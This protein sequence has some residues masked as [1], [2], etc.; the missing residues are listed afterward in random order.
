MS[1][2]Y[3]SQF[4]RL[5]FVLPMVFLGACGDDDAARVVIE[6]E[7]VVAKIGA[8][9]DSAVSGI[10]YATATYVGTTNSEGEFKYLEGETVTF[11][12]GAISLPSTLAKFVITPVDLVGGE[13]DPDDSTVL[14]IARFLQTIDSDNVSENGI[15]IDDATVA[16]ATTNIS[17]TDINFDSSAQLFIDSLGRNDLLGQPL[18]LIEPAVAEVHLRQT[19]DQIEESQ[20]SNAF[21]SGNTFTVAHDGGDIAELYFN[22][23]SSET[24]NT[25]SIRYSNGDSRTISEWVVN[26]DG[27]LAFTEINGSISTN[28]EFV[29]SSV[30]GSQADYT[31]NKPDVVFDP[32]GQG[33]M[34]LIENA[35]IP[36]FL[37]GDSLQGL[38]FDIE[39]QSGSDLSKLSF[40][41][42]VNGNGEAEP[43]TGTISRGSELTNFNWSI[44]L[45]VLTITENITGND[46]SLWKF[47]AS[48]ITD[49]IAEYNYS[50]S[51]EIDGDEFIANGPG[52]ITLN[53]NVFSKNYLMGESLN[54]NTFNLGYSDTTSSLT[55]L[56]FVEL[57]DATDEAG[58]ATLPMTGTLVRGGESYEFQWS[59]ALGVLTII[60]SVGVANKFRFMST[61]LLE[62]GIM[63]Y[64]FT[65]TIT[66][67]DEVQSASGSG[68][69]TLVVNDVI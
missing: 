41:E 61:S 30:V 35:F 69:M 31:Y 24:L 23:H 27:E 28:W 50:R 2:N 39:H 42:V 38:I 26:D 19:I 13:A 47:T 44:D 49:E 29:E 1:R 64:D 20:L 63:E 60:E 65:E 66:E 8:F 10:D 25:G 3:K 56:S 54:G 7:E 46:T 16:A 34:T 32:T 22:V 40:V 21:L 67:N 45:G 62:S 48:S 18:Q 14:N 36:S 57:L 17:F 5:C 59:L 6:E 52:E 43:F 58:E 33:R 9:L 55:Q 4:M 51:F 53:K 11:S 37:L 12:V 68:T 15:T